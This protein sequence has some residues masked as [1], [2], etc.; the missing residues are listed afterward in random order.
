MALRARGKASSKDPA[1]SSSAPAPDIADVAAASSRRPRG[2]EAAAEL[3]A[4]RL[5]RQ[6]QAREERAREQQQAQQRPPSTTDFPAVPI[7]TIANLAIHSVLMLV[8]PLGLYY[9][10]VH[11]LLDPVFAPAFGAVRRENRPLLGGVLAVLGVNAVVVSFLVRA[12]SEVESGGGA[13][14]R[15]AGTSR[16][17]D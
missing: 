12:F 3:S 16:K 6:E 15:R 9:S 13:G 1:P 7:S 2:A 4:Q 17:R 5:T 14:A 8:L 11:G 10:A